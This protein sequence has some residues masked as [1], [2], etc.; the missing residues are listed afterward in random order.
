ME[1]SLILA[2]AAIGGNV[3]IAVG[4]IATWSKNGRSQAVKYG[5][6]RTEVKNNG[7]KVD[8]L[9]MAFNGLDARV[10]KFQETSARQDE[11]LKGVEQEIKKVS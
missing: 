5:E 9:T 7:D 1:P 3:L 2:T 4:L 6:L 10:G 11:R 8:T